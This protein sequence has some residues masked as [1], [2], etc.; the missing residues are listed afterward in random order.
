MKIPKELKK[1]KSLIKYVEDRKGHD[2]RYAI[3]PNKIT[4]ELMEAKI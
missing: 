4:R 3:N 1:P 2:K